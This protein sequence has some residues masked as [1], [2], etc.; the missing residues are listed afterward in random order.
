MPVE[1][2]DA[3]PSTVL[4]YKKAHHIGRFDPNATEIQQQKIREAWEE[5]EG[6]SER[7]S[8]PILPCFLQH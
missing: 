7:S 6:K 1:T 2:Y 3:L 5:I 4:A 8:V